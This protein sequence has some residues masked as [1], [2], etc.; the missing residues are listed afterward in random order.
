MKLLIGLL[1]A[2]AVVA[3]VGLTSG[4]LASHPVTPTAH[5]TPV[6]AQRISARLFFGLEGPRGSVPEA[7]WDSFLQDVVV[8]RFP[9]GLTVIHA[10]G[11]WQPTS[12]PPQREASRVLEIVSD[13]TPHAHRLIEQIAALYKARFQQDS[14][15]VVRMPANV[16]F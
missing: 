8:A 10:K 12:G 13:D 3:G 14:V 1:V 4:V 15:M 6:C 5:A 11:H 9:N 16:C 2:G 7:E